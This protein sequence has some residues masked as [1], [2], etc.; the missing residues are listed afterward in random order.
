MLKRVAKKIGEDLA[1]W[2]EAPEMNSMLGDA[3]AD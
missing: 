2:L 3:A 1:E